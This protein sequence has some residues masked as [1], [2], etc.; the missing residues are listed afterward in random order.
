MKKIQLL[1]L[2]MMFFVIIAGC[3]K[4]ETKDEPKDETN[5]L[6]TFAE[7]FLTQLSEGKY[8]EAM[9]RFDETMSAQLTASDLETLWQTLEQQIG[10]QVT[11]IY[12]STQE[13]DGYQVVLFDG[14]FEAADVV[15]RV[16]FDDENQIAGFFIQ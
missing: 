11:I 14:T 3:N 10:K 9:D 8:T 5:Q 1:T 2:V 16:S 6:V 13:V 12:N 7:E 4:Q 15:F